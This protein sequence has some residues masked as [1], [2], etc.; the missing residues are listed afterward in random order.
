MTG[1]LPRDLR[2]GPLLEV[3]GD[4]PL[5]LERG[6]AW[7][8]RAGRL[9]VFA[10]RPGGRRTHLF[11]VG[12]DGLVLGVGAHAPS[13]LSLLAV[14]DT[15]T[16]LA[17]VDAEAARGRGELVEGWVGCV[18]EAMA[19]VHGVRRY[20][21]VAPGEMAGVQA[22]ECLRV[23]ERVG[24]VEM[25]SGRGC[26]VGRAAAPLH[27]G[28]PVPLAARGWF[29]AAEA[30]GVW[31]LDFAAVA[32][33]G[34]VAP[35]LE[36]LHAA[37][38]AVVDER[39]READAAHRARLRERAGETGAAMG[40]ALTRLAAP[41][42]PRA[43]RARL[44][45][46]RP[47]RAEDPLL[48]AFHQVLEAAGIARDPDARVPPPE[49]R[50]RD[51]VAALVRA[52]RVR[53]RRVALRG[54]W[55][56]HDAGP[57]LGA[58]AE[59]DHPVALLPDR[60]GGYHL[61]D[62]RTPGRMRVDRATAE[63][64]APFAHTFYRPFPAGRLGLWRLLRFGAQ[65]SRGDLW[66]MA[67]AA[68]VVG[69]LGLVTPYAVGLLFGEVLPSA[70]RGQLLQLTL[71]L[72]AAAVAA[73]G[74][75]VVRGVAL[76][77][78]EA[79]S[80]A[81]M[82]S[83]VWDRLLSLP[84]SFFR[85]Y[86]AGDLAVRAMAVEEIR[87]LFTGRVA[88]TLLGGVFS[89]L[90]FVL[91]F[92]YDARL[93]ALAALLVGGSVAAS[94]AAGWAQ[95]RLQRQVI[96]LRSRASGVVL[97]LLSGIGKLKA[98]VAEVQAFGIWARLFSEQRE[99][100]YRAR[101]LGIRLAA[102]NAA[103]PVLCALALFAAAAP[104]LRAGGDLPMGEFLAFVAAFTLSLSAGLAASTAVV[105]ALAAAPLYEQVRPI[106]DAEPEVGAARL[107]PG[108][109]AGDIEVQH[110]RFRYG[111]DGP[112]VL[113]DLSLR[114]RPGEFVAFVGP[115]GSGK[116]TL[117]RVLLGFEAPESGAVYY[118][119]QDLS[120]LDVQAV[121]R[122]IGVVL[123]AGKVMHGDL[124]TNIAGA[125]AV[126]VDDAWEAARMAGLDEDIRQMPMGMHT[127]VSD[128][129]GT[130]SGG[131]RQRLMIARAVVHRPRILFLDEATSAL[132]NRT[133]QIVGE[134]LARL[135]ATRVVIAHRLSTILHAD[136]IYVLENGVIVENGTYAELMSR[137]GA[138]AALARRQLA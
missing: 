88:D 121:R 52:E 40:A 104:R 64:L 15:A 69:A 130:L 111:E 24:W 45:P 9:D 99:R 53:G 41:L 91:L 120:G 79:R 30:A 77:R 61:S 63:T 114:I 128:G 37:F 65:G 72:L 47:A 57:L 70:E 29:C 87:R 60:R 78:V 62:P 1:P 98:A 74:F 43:E 73:A 56:R 32:E 10:V 117:L 116:S 132:D 76:V 94:L 95:L 137:G 19:D 127:I 101:T 35:A 33:R 3:R 66:R 38:L 124:F 85:G 26:L 36:R 23:S 71:V 122:Q 2:P 11:R 27:V 126:S 20:Q 100:Q 129:G 89:L 131:Q 82:Q 108:D 39:L 67:G 58:A 18:Y 84:L 17:E 138:F 16:A 21:A 110:L 107:D 28:E 46:A 105:D 90:N 103:L 12:A 125:S 8:V 113:R 81:A 112:L 133:Q 134:S 6:R 80:G 49:G 51:P 123:Q 96:G 55:W 115:S 44:F 102:F 59:G 42:R 119:E 54:E 86:A 13:G 135:Q 93:A 14:G 97:Q 25:I 34:E 50:G 68:A 22:G 106:L 136:C 75:Q 31:V 5:V 109:L 83:A 118:D 7:V 4:R 48:A 92:H